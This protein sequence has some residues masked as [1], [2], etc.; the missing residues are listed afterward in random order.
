LGIVP[1]EMCQIVYILVLNSGRLRGVYEQMGCIL[2]PWPDSL[3]VKDYINK[4]PC[5]QTPPKHHPQPRPS[6]LNKKT[7]ATNPA[8][9]TLNH[10][11]PSYPTSSAP[12]PSEEA[13]PHSKQIPTDDHPHHLPH[14]I[15]INAQLCLTLLLCIQANNRSLHPCTLYS[16]PN[17]LFE[18]NVLASEKSVTWVALCMYV[19][20]VLSENMGR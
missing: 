10:P 15:C 12:K 8:Q 18:F 13:S 17:T 19:R 1:L 16:N 4:Y 6:H 7:Q 2:V 11:T 9:T 14:R 5:K 3:I 20:D